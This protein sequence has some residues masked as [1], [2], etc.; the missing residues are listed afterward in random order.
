MRIGIVGDL[1]LPFDHPGYLHFCMDTFDQWQVDHV[2]FIGD[3]VE[4]HRLSQWEDNPEGHSAEREAELAQECVDRW[5]KVWPEA[6]VSIG[7][8]DNRHYRKA[9]SVGVPDRYVKTYKDVWNTPKWDWQDNHI[10]DGVLY[11]H[12]TGSSGKNAAINR[13]VNKRSSVVIG[14][15]HAWGGVTYH[16]NETSRIFALNVGC[17]I[18]ITAYCFAYGASMPNRPTLG[19]GVVL[20]G[21]FGV[22]EPMRCGEGEKY[23]RRKFE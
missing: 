8:H 3:V 22:F 5:T 19:C 18:D 1:H 14:H 13:A 11:E 20:D 6:T 21:W 23:N 12:G 16:S 4:H 9:R 17:G 10:H 7:N 2:H 15:T